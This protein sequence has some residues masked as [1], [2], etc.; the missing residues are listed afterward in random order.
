MVVAGLTTASATA[1]PVKTQAEALADDAAQY[2]AHYRV[3][4][5]EAVLRLQGQQA[6]V[7][8]TDAIAAEFA[9][10]LAG[11][12]I[13]HSPD[14]RIV[15]L[16]TGVEPVAD[17]SAGGVPIVFHT[18]ARATR[19]QAIAA[20]RRHL[21]DLR[22]ELPGARGAGYDQRTGE[23]VLLVTS[24]DAQRFGAAAIRAR[25]EQLGGV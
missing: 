24:A 11:I 5:D 22:N 4:L 14:Y 7:P 16:L 13:E 6:S 21:I 10:R 20:M 2:A 1:Q 17:R 19:A 18:G 12:S 8:T 25:A 15:V 9:S 3:P 23:I